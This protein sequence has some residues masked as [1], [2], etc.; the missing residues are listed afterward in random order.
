MMN[1]NDF[2]WNETKLYLESIIDQTEY[3]KST[4]L[5]Q[6]LLSKEHRDLGLQLALQAQAIVAIMNFI[7]SKKSGV[8]NENIRVNE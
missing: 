4:T 5:K 8:T 7:E 6:H 3:W 1:K 2:P